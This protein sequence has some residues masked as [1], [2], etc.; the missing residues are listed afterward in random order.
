MAI[1]IKHRTIVRD[2]WRRLDDDAPLAS[3]DIRVA[4]PTIVSLAWWRNNREHV[5][6]QR[7]MF[8]VELVAADN[9]GDL[10]I[11][12]DSVGTDDALTLVAIHFGSQTDGRGFSN[13]RL[14]R[15]RFGYRGELRATGSIIID[16]LWELERCGFDAMELASEV[17]A[18]QIER[19]FEVFS[20]SYQAAATA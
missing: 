20:S 2:N 18:D 10:A 9:P 5:L 4:V 11:D 8:G 3:A 6:G 16:Q 1:L 17:S 12:V 7:S 15:D 19:A 13:A 14:L